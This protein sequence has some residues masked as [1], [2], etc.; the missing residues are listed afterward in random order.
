MGR[1]RRSSRS[2]SKVSGKVLLS[3]ANLFV[4]CALLAVSCLGYLFAHLMIGE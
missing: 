4:A 2:R 1:R 3:R